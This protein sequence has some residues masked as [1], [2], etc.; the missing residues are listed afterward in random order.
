VVMIFFKNY[1][2]EKIKPFMVGCE[3]CLAIVGEYLKGGYQ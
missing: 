3:I 1:E 2:R